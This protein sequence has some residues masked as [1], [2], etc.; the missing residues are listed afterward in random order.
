MFDLSSFKIYQ[1]S[2]LYNI[3]SIM[4]M[5]RFRR[6]ERGLKLHAVFSADTLNGGTIIIGDNNNYA[7]AA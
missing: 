1:I 6:G 2:R 4:G 3:F 5:Q 7:L